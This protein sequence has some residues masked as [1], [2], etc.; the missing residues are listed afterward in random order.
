MSRKRWSV[1]ELQVCAAALTFFVAGCV[2]SARYAESGEAPILADI[3]ATR[4][5]LLITNNNSFVW[6]QVTFTVNGT[7]Q[8]QMDVVPRGSTSITLSSFVDD[9]GRAFTST[10]A[11]LR[12]VDIDVAGSSSGTGGSYQW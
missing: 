5:H 9:F 7:Y 1:Y 8:Y 6:R 12:H 11:G 2:P 10:A 4:Q 3:G